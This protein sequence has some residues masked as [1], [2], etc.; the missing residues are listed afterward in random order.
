[1]KNEGSF[2]RFKQIICDYQEDYECD[3]DN[4]WV[5]DFKNAVDKA[6]GSASKLD[7]EIHDA[8]Y[9]AQYLGFVEGM[10]FALDIMEMTGSGVNK[11]LIRKFL[12]ILEK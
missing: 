2:E 9:A 5:S 12:K 8:V 7:E 4:R 1:M 6:T 10:K 3:S 11:D